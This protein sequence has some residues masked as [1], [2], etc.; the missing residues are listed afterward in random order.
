[1]KLKLFFLILH[2]YELPTY[3]GGVMYVRICDGIKRKRFR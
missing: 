1:M 3:V 2:V